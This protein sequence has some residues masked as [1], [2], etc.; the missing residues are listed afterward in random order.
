MSTEPCPPSEPHR[1]RPVHVAIED[2]GL[3]EELRAY[4]EDEVV[5]LPVLLADDMP[6]TVCGMQLCEE[7]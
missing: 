4:I 2:R 1:D 3:T 5:D 7:R 6:L